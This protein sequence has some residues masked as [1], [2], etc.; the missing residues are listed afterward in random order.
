[1]NHPIGG[2]DAPFYADREE[3]LAWNADMEAWVKVG[4]MKVARYHH[5][6]STINMQELVTYCG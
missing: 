2:S 5:A 1:M 6:L 4:L 3:I